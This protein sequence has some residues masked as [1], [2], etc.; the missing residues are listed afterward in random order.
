ME[1]SLREWNDG[2]ELVW[3]WLSVTKLC[4]YQR[5]SD[6]MQW[7]FRKT[8]GQL[9]S[10]LQIWVNFDQADCVK[11]RR[12]SGF[13]EFA[14]ARVKRRDIGREGVAS[15]R[16]IVNVRSVVIVNGEGLEKLGDFIW[17]YVLPTT[18]AIK[19]FWLSDVGI[20]ASMIPDSMSSIEWLRMC[21]RYG[22]EIGWW[23]FSEGRS[24][25]WNSM[26]RSAGDKDLE[27][28]V[29]QRSSREMKRLRGRML[30]YSDGFKSVERMMTMMDSMSMKVCRVQWW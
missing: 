3:W 22:D 4:W 1:N 29:T 9:W 6:P 13:R 8:I 30:K 12:E 15:M 26:L 19:V 21:V 20:I 17:W 10:K 16:V 24:L 28:S 11:V 5:L 14:I 2:L 25:T 18:R 7:S 27:M 23:N